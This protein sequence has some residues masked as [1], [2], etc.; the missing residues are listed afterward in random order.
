MA[1]SKGTNFLNCEILLHMQN[2]NFYNIF[3]SFNYNICS[4]FSN[5]SNDKRNF[6]KINIIE[7]I[8]NDKISKD[9]FLKK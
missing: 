7:L 4:K 5:E 1:K 3:I 6:Q 8:D 2:A 9:Y